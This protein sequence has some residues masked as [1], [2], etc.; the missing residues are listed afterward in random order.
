MNKLLSLLFICILISCSQ[1][2]EST[3]EYKMVWS[4]EFDQTNSRVDDTKWFMETVAPNNGAWYNDELQHYTDRLD[5]ASVSDGTLKITAKK[6][7]YTHSGTTQAYTSAR[8][9]SKFSFTY[10]KVVVRA[11][12]P[13]EQGTWPAI[14]TLGSNLETVGWPACGE[15]DIMEQLFED[16]EMVQCAV[17]TPATH[18]DNTIVKQVDITDV[19]ANFHNYGME[20]NADKIDFTVDDQVY[21]TYSPEVKTPEN[22]P[23][24]NDQYILLNIAMGGN[25]GGTVDPNFSEDV[26]EVDFVRVYQKK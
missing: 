15:I 4:D 23:F 25:L 9:N 10:G 1:K 14:W 16:F 20:W 19:T 17:H 13:R 18:G 5:N 6:E 26:M 7:E 21:F 2:K 8:L 11:K 22:W 24:F 12:L 3:S